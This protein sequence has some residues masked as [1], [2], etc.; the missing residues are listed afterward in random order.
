MGT[1]VC[2]FSVYTSTNSL[3]N[4]LLCIGV[5]QA[6]HQ[7][8]SGRQYINEVYKFSVDKMYDLLFTESEFMRGFREQ[9]RF[10]GK[11]ITLYNIHLI[12]TLFAVWKLLSLVPLCVVFLAGR[13]L[14][15]ISYK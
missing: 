5:V 6:F 13:K 12:N 4:I 7:D 15:A 3:T 9:Q 2:L 11:V 10:S 14:N 1:N 8:Q